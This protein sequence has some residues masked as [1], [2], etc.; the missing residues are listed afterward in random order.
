ME[1]IDVRLSADYMITSLGSE[2]LDVDTADAE[3]FISRSS[4]GTGVTIK[5]M[6]HLLLVSAKRDVSDGLLMKLA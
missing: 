5:R 3:S 1:F 4:D 6:S 2:P